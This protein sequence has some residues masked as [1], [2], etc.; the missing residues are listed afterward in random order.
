MLGKN[1]LKE[2]SWLKLNHSLVKP[3]KPHIKKNI[4]LLKFIYLN[5]SS[6]IGQS[7]NFTIAGGG[8]GGGMVKG[9]GN[10]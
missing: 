1:A 6:S 5:P 8:G 10:N 9:M 4:S 3:Q 7:Q 2:N